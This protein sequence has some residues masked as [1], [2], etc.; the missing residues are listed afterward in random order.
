MPNINEDILELI[1]SSTGEL[2][3][4]FSEG[5]GD[6]IRLSLFT[7]G[8]DFVESSVKAAASTISQGAKEAM[9]LASGTVMNPRLELTFQG[10]DRRSFSYSFKILLL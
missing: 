5:S 1:T 8:G 3:Y 7:Q 6:Y 4:S 2:D 10:I 9:E